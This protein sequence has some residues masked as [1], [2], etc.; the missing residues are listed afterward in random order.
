MNIEVENMNIIFQAMRNAEMYVMKHT[1]LTVQCRLEVVTVRSDAQHMLS[2]IAETLEEDAAMFY[3]KSRTR[4][5]V[6][7][8]MIA[9][10]LVKNYYT[11][12][13]LVEIGKLFGEN[14]IDHS[15][16]RHYINTVEALLSNPDKPFTKKYTKVFNAIQLW[17]RK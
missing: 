12:M 14:N 9:T 10:Y 8:R 7:M 6:D 17:L 13:T 2:M 3:I 11:D 5:L 15:T 4:S 1:G 16:I